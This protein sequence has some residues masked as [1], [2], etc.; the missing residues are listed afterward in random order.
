MQCLKCQTKMQRFGKTSALNQRW[1][2]PNCHT[3]KTEK[4]QGIQISDRVLN[5]IKKLP[6]INPNKKQKEIKD[7]SWSVDYYIEQILRNH[8]G[9]EADYDN[10]DLAL[11]LAGKKI[12]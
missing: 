10:R 5:E 1:R 12:V 7:D 9:I 8:L 3:T 11:I 6:Q 4:Q 2:C